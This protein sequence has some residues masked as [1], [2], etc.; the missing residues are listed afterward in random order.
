MATSNFWPQCSNYNVT[1]IIWTAL[2]SEGR[3]STV[4][5]FLSGAFKV[6]TKQIKRSD[7]S[8]STSKPKNEHLMD[9]VQAPTSQ[10]LL[11]LSLDMDIYGGRLRKAKAKAG[12]LGEG[13][14]FSDMMF[15]TKRSLSDACS[16]VGKEL[17]NVSSSVRDAKQFLST[18]IDRVDSNIDACHKLACDTIAEVSDLKGDLLVFGVDVESV[19]RVVQ[20][21]ETKIGRIE[22]K[23]DITTKGI[24]TLCGFVQKLEKN[25]TGA[26]LQAPSSSSSR[27]ALEHPHLTATSRTG[28]L[29][30]RL[31]SPEPPSPSSVKSSR[32]LQGTFSAAGLKELQEI[33]ET[34]TVSESETPQKNVGEDTKIDES[35][36]SGLFGWKFPGFNASVL[37]RTRSVSFNK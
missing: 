1:G 28:S 23:Q 10:L 5:D 13:W 27:L 24:R 19:H 32:T 12:L 11:S 31:L 14:K 25:E 22:G 26:F 35:P 15:A 16:T 2:A 34:L 36:S 29:P 18:R 9:Q 6:V 30:P 8:P 20:N 17:D 4:S 33:S 37:S 3:A 7:T 21:L